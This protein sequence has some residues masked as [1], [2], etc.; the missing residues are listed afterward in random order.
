[1]TEPGIEEQL[2]SGV[3]P[4]DRWMSLSAVVLLKSPA[5][6]E[7][8]GITFYIPNHAKARSVSLMLD[9][10]EV[11][12]QS[13]PGPGKYDLL[14]QMPLAPTSATATV[15]ISVDQTFTAP[16]DIRELGVLL[17]GVGFRP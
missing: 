2:I 14:S 15:E 8:L 1:M 7:P 11:T 13:F 4:N 10:K 9:G 12:T 17:I 6:P 16:P 3:W 5:V